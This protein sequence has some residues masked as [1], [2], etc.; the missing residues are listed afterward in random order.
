MRAAPNVLPMSLRSR[1]RNAVLH[2]TF[3]YATLI[4]AYV[5]YL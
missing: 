2:Y 1:Y 3:G 4:E 5:G